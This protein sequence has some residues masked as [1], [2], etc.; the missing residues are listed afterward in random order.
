MTKVVKVDLDLGP[1]ITE[2]SGYELVGSCSRCGA[3]CVAIGCQHV[4]TEAVDGQLLYKCDIYWSR[5]YGCALWPKY[6]DE[7]PESCGFAWAEIT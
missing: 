7:L 2:D 4:G 1:R 5:P 6:E 3:C